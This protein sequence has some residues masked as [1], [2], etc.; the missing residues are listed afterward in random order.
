[1][2]LGARSPVWAIL[3]AT[4]HGKAAA[5]GMPPDARQREVSQTLSRAR[6]VATPV[7]TCV[8]VADGFQSDWRELAH[9]LP[10]YNVMVQPAGGRALDAIEHALLA[11][12]AREG[13]CSVMM[14]PVDHCAAV[15]SAWVTSAGEALTL[16]AGHADTVY[17]L[18]DKSESIE[19][20]FTASTDLCSTTV[21]VGSTESLLGL[22]QGTRQARV[23]ELNTDD[24]STA[25]SAA[26]TDGEF[27]SVS[28]APVNIVRI[29]SVE[30]YAR[31]Q[32]GLYSRAKP[33]FIDLR[34]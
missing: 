2:P 13:D 7:R 34:V 4:Q 16:A 27:D 14:I 28:E 9:E 12:R 23:I 20:A 10:I 15:E 32:Q 31:L 22:A 25:T 30:E 1:V 33:S 18:H 5:A 26:A 19:A 8:L 29:R 6:A 3:V 11:I 21:V 17:L 24:E